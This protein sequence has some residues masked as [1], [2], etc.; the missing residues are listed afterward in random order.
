MVYGQLYILTE[1]VGWLGWEY[2]HLSG[3]KFPDADVYI[4]LHAGEKESYLWS[5]TRQ[6]GSSDRTSALAKVAVPV[7]LG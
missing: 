3:R 6:A 1:P 4:C 7:V 2:D 5:I